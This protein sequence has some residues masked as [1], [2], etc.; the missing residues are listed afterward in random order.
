MNG[1]QI[2]MAD[3][4]DPEL[5]LLMDTLKPQLHIKQLSLRMTLRLTEQ[6]FYR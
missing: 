1:F 5:P 2:M 4:E 6:I 3:Q